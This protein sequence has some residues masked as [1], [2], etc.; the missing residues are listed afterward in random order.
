VPAYGDLAIG[1]AL[2]QDLR[3]SSFAATLDAAML[4][5]HIARLESSRRSCATSWSQPKSGS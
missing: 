1:R 4:R 2:A 3:W 5:E